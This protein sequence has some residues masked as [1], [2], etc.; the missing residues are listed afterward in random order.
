[1]KKFKKIIIIYHII[2]LRLKLNNNS[3]NN[4]LSIGKLKSPKMKAANS[5]RVG[6]S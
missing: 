4:N 1:M 3:Y 2:L 6:L 5:I